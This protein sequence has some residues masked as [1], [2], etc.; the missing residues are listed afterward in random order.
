MIQVVK[1]IFYFGPLLFAF[2]FMA[3]LI[4]QVVRATGWTP[5]FEL[6][7]LMFGLIVAGTYGVIAQV[8]GRWV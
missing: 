7:P 2:G 1:T 6:S 4:A 5:S 3:P 8:R